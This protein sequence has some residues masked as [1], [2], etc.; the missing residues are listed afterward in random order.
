VKGEGFVYTFRKEDGVLSS[1]LLEDKEILS[2]GPRLNV[3]RAPLANDLDSWNFRRTEMGHVTEGMGKET[4]NG[5][6]SIGLDQLEQVVDH[7]DCSADV[8][9]V[10]VHVEASL[11]ARNYTTGFKVFYDYTIY[12]NGKMKVDTR[13]SAR[14]N[15]TKWIPKV[16]LQ[17]EMPGAFQQMEWFGRG[18]FET[19]PDRLTGAKMGIYKTTVE[20]AYVPYIIPQ[21]YGNRSEVH[22]FKL[23]DHEGTGLYISAPQT[24]DVSAQK[25]TTDNLDRAHYPFQ[26]IEQDVVTLNLDHRVTGVG[27]T[28]NSVLNPYRVAPGEFQF[29]FTLKP[30]NH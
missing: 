25:Y 30:L 1:M 9:A 17:M 14:G 6:R 10:R 13:V 8:Q 29:S 4:A 23:S 26:L 19:Y 21:D 20:E 7:F 18:P 2:K 11:T 5:W 15:M 28:A 3:W 22:W 27:G 16:G 24:F 12:G